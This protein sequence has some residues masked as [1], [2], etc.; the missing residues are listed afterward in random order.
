MFEG[1]KKFN[2]IPSIRKIKELEYSLKLSNEYIL[3][4][5]VHIGNLKGLVDMCHKAN[6]HVAVNMDLISGLALDKVGISLLRKLYNVDIVIGSN[7]SKINMAKSMGMKVIHR[8]IL[9][10]S[11]SLDSAFKSIESSK[12]DAI[13]VIPSYYGIKFAEDIKQIRDVPL[14]LGG[15]IDDVDIIKTAASKGFWGVTV[16][17]RE[18]WNIKLQQNT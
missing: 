16:S 12:A 7:V 17:D 15:F 4:S 13:E 6:K 3:L 1:N 14:I 10:D 8:V 11:R 2:I 5:D 18:V 9:M